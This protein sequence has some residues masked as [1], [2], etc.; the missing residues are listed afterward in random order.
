MSQTL[1]LLNLQTSLRDT[2]LGASAEPLDGIVADDRLGYAQRINVYRNNTHILL[3]DALATNFPVV[4]ALVGDDFFTNMARA[5]LRTHPP[6]SPCLFEYGD[7]FATFI[8]TFPGAQ[9]LPYLADTARLEWARA[10]AFHAADAHVLDAAQ[11]TNIEAE[12]YGRLTFTAHS[13]MRVVSSP[14]PIFAIWDLH[15]S[16]ADASVDLNQG[17]EAV[18]ITRSGMGVDVTLLG[19]GED[20]FILDL[21]DGETLGNAFVRAQTHCDTFDAAHALSLILTQATF[22]AHA[23][24]LL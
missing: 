1:S 3:I 23:L 7:T 19:A 12:A 14:F 6:Q 2:I 24:T 4:A 21:A 8:E 13:A 15:Q 16:G 10:Q 22:S 5:F 20:A 9:E 17:G 18:L 11:L